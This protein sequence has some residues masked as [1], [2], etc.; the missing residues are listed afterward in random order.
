MASTG[1]SCA[2]HDV[3]QAAWVTGG[4]D[5][6]RLRRWR[7]KGR[8]K[9]G[10]WRSKGFLS[11]CPVQGL[12]PMNFATTAVRLKVIRKRS[13]TSPPEDLLKYHVSSLDPLI[14]KLSH[15]WN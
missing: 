14:L 2:Q 3:G 1:N 9:A 8:G 6:G 7:N 4:Q 11:G 13:F 15:R 12:P 5:G 10:R